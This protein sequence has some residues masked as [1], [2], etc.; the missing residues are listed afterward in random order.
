MLTKFSLGMLAQRALTLQEEI[1]EIHAILK[2]LVKETPPGLSAPWHRHRRRF[3]TVGYGR[4]QS[5]RRRNEAALHLCG[6][7]PLD[8]SSGS[9][10]VTGSTAVVIAKPTRLCGTS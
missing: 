5:Q 7:S 1:S 4:R 6:A 10:S 2:P 8:A 3:G 9:R